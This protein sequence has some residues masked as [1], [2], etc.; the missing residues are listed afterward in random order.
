[1]SYSAK[2]LILKTHF[3]FDF[4]NCS[5]VLLS[6][7]HIPDSLF[8]AILCNSCSRDLP[9]KFR[10]PDGP[11]LCD[12]CIKTKWGVSYDKKSD[13]TSIVDQAGNIQTFEGK[14][15]PDALYLDPN[16]DSVTAANCLPKIKEYR[17]K[18]VTTRQRIKQMRKHKNLTRYENQS[19]E[20][21]RLHQ[22]HVKSGNSKQMTLRRLLFSTVINDP[23]NEQRDATPFLEQGHPVYH[24]TMQPLSTF[25]RNKNGEIEVMC[26]QDLDESIRDNF[27]HK[28]GGKM[29]GIWGTLCPFDCFT[30]Q[31]NHHGYEFKK[32]T[33]LLLFSFRFT[34]PTYG[35][36]IQ[37]QGGNSLESRVYGGYGEIPAR[38]SRYCFNIH[39]S[40]PNEIIAV[41]F[42][43]S[44]MNN[45][46]LSVLYM[47]GKEVNITEDDTRPFTVTGEGV[48][49]PDAPLENFVNF[50]EID[51]VDNNMDEEST[52][53]E[54]QHGHFQQTTRVPDID[55]ISVSEYKGKHLDHRPEMSVDKS[56]WKLKEFKRKSLP[57]KKRKKWKIRERKRCRHEGC[58][59]LARGKEGVC[60]RHGAKRKRCSHD[61][62]TNQ[63]QTGGVCWR[64][65]AKRKRCSHDGRR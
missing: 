24:G 35:G 27:E 33:R 2:Y 36:W 7:A 51:H 53:T 3:T 23:N 32:G 26:F 12:T 60:F 17:A 19:M 44:D 25:K 47:N 20:K 15:Y 31:K 59:N 18:F 43:D 45:A 40:V 8:D 58:A 14:A 4:V 34:N 42:E 52:S 5:Y 28:A 37:Y 65:G 9:K 39:N 10:I 29:R 22:K 48:S 54:T 56:P 49:H 61:G 64:H 46:K 41:D 50:S 62:C 38:L 1:M 6:S 11:I 16:T 13:I 55:D 57:K 21:F 63:E 30:F